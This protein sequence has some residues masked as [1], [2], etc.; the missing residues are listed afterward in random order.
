MGKELRYTRAGPRP[1]DLRRSCLENTKAASVLGWKPIITLDEGL[2]RTIT[3]F[4]AVFQFKNGPLY[5][6]GVDRI[7]KH[8]V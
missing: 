7:V 2:A 6:K 3:Y 5:F 4:E 1:G 8:H